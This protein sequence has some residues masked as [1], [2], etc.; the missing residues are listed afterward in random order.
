MSLDYKIQTLAF[1]NRGNSWMIVIVK[2]VIIEGLH[3]DF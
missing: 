3:N 2:I 1:A